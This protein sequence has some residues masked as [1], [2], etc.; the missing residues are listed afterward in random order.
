MKVSKGNKKYPIIK[1]G[2]EKH[3]CNK[4]CCTANNFIQLVFL[5][6]RLCLR[7]IY[8]MSRIWPYNSPL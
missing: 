8:D 3:K 5:N 6:L 7:V 4:L 2:F 1:K